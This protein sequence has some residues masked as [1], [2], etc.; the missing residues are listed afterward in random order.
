MVFAG[1]LFSVSSVL[2]CKDVN[3]VDDNCGMKGTM[4]CCQHKAKVTVKATALT[5]DP[6][7]LVATLMPVTFSKLNQ[8]IKHGP[9]FPPNPWDGKLYLA[10]GTLKTNC[11][12]MS[13]HNQVPHQDGTFPPNPWACRTG[14]DMGFGCAR[15][16]CECGGASLRSKI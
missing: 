13:K 14:C 8:G 16:G 11:P 15:A 7:E 6:I 9:M 5:F 10:S 12:F 3:G 4:S 1:M 2:A